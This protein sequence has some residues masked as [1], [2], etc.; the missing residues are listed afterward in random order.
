[1][2]ESNAPFFLTDKVAQ[3]V[4]QRFSWYLKTMSDVTTSDSVHYGS[5]IPLFTHLEPGPLPSLDLSS[6]LVS[7]CELL[8]SVAAKAYLNRGMSAATSDIPR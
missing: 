1:M 3:Y 4:Q 5:F 6:A 7:D 8:A 2:L